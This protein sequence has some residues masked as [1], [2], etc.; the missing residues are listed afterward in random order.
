MAG[1]SSFLSAHQRQRK[2]RLLRLHLTDRIG[3]VLHG[4]ELAERSLVAIEG[5]EVVSTRNHK[6]NARLAIVA[7]VD[8]DHRRRLALG[9]DTDST[10]G[11]SSKSRIDNPSV[12]IR[13]RTS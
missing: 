6:A 7:A 5:L 12:R 13:C 9:H 10:P 2:R 3:R 11:A 4:R 8:R 1:P